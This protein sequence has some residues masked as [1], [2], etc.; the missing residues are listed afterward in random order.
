LNIET[1][2]PKKCTSSKG[3]SILCS[4]LES[5]ICESGVGNINNNECIWMKV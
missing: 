2:P 4:N 5:S 3:V 1:D